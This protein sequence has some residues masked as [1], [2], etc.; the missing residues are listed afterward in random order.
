MS[1]E[2]KACPFC[3]KQAVIWF[4]NTPSG[5]MVACNNSGCAFC[6][7]PIRIDRWNTRPIEDE[8]REQLAKY[9]TGE[10]FSKH[11]AQ[12]FE[13]QR[14]RIEQLE[15]DLSQTDASNA[16]MKN[17]LLAIAAAEDTHRT[18]NWCVRRV[19]EALSPE[20]ETK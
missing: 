10:T 2:I 5:D 18:V 3:G 15:S 19:K 4:K 17:A 6:Q 1:D 12:V 13:Q 8:L 20:S 16:V 14:Q 7:E 9:E 11:A